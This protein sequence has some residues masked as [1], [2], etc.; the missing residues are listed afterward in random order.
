MLQFFDKMKILIIIP[1]FPE[2]LEDIKGGVQ[3]ALANLL[4]GFA[5]IN[6]NIRVITFSRTINILSIILLQ[7]ILFT[8]K[9]RQV[10]IF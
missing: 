2:N 3:S 1:D 6:E 5:I 9:K 8:A 7:L 10:F 4:K